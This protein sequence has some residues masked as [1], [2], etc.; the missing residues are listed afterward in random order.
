MLETISFGICVGIFGWIFVTQ[1]KTRPLFASV[2][3]AFAAVAVVVFVIAST[4]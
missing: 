1:P 2:A 4:S 3:V